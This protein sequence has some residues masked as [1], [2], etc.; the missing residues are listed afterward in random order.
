MTD[1]E[2]LASSN[3]IGK[4][5][6]HEQALNAA[7]QA[8]AKAEHNQAINEW[9]DKYA[10]NDQS[11]SPISQMLDLGK[12]AWHYDEHPDFEGWPT[13]IANVA[14]E[15]PSIAYD[16]AS[17]LVDEYIASPLALPYD[18]G[19]GL[20]AGGLEAAYPANMPIMVVPR[21]PF[22]EADDTYDVRLPEEFPV[23]TVLKQAWN[24]AKEL[25]K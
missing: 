3:A 15:L 8:K 21:A 5:S 22:E 24:K 10:S 7:E 13:T 16:M 4:Q 12:L 18:I 17:G 9:L 1:E 25:F 19:T 14:Q 11:Y 2:L 6:G 23:R 20:L